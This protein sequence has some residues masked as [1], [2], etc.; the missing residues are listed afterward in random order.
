MSFIQVPIGK[1]IGKFPKLRFSQP[2]ERRPEQIPHSDLSFLESLAEDSRLIFLENQITAS[3]TLISITPDT[4]TTFFFLK[5]SVQNFDD[6][7]TTDI[8]LI[9]AGTTREQITLAPGERHTFQL[10]FDRLVGNMSNSFQIDSAEATT[11]VQGSLYGW[12][13]NTERIA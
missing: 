8:T 2:E 5:A 10:P 11:Q 7:T 4:G 9:N 3:G 13:E 6:T 12:V 1:G